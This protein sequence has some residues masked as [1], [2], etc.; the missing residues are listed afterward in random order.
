MQ[1]TGLQGIIYKGQMTPYPNDKGY[2]QVTGLQKISCISQM[3]PCP[4]LKE[5]GITRFLE[6]SQGGF[7]F[8]K[9][10]YVISSNNTVKLVY[11]GDRKLL[12]NTFLNFLRFIF[13]ILMF[14]IKIEKHW[15]WFSFQKSQ[16]SGFGG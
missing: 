15:I 12:K 11:L 1:T 16:K 3:T 5:N 14:V 4:M 2:M 8:Q 9:E 7:H 10:P 6:T 13:E